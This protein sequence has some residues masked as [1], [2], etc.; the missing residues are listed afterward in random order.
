V[1]GT[2]FTCPLGGQRPKFIEEKATELIPD[3]NYS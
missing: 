2:G 3:R 1:P